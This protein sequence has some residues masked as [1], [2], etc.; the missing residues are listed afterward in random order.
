MD[1]QILEAIRA[2]I[3]QPNAFTALLVVCLFFLGRHY[4][5][6]ADRAIRECE[7]KHSKCERRLGSMIRL[8]A[9]VVSVEDVATYD[10]RR[11]K[12]RRAQDEARAAV[13][14]EVRRSLDG[15]LREIEHEERTEEHGLL[16][17]G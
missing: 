2:F 11:S 16:S 6:R 15:M 8:L 17:G 9:K 13:V 12:Q 4:W 10:A 5:S 7:V 14:T 1:F 3:T